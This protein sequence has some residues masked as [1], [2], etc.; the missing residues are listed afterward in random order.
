M[1]SEHTADPLMTKPSID[2]VPELISLEIPLATSLT[3]LASP[4]DKP[5]SISIDPSL[6]FLK[7]HCLLPKALPG[8]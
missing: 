8:L 6:T 1:V 5:A 3:P 2:S 4:N 7:M